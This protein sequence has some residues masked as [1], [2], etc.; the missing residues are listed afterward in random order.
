MAVNRPWA[1]TDARVM[2][3]I[4]QQRVVHESRVCRLQSDLLTVGSGPARDI[5]APPC[6]HL[7]PL[8]SMVITSGRPAESFSMTVEDFGKF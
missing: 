3:P 5:A 1:I 8:M 2:R 4:G 7:K 6:R